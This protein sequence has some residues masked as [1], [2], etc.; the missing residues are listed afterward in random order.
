[1]DATDEDAAKMRDALLTAGI[2]ELAGIDE[3]V[4]W[5]IVHDTFA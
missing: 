4:W 2:D 1:V 5:Q 3:K